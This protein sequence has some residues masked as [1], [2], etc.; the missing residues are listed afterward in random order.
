MGERRG[1]A[2]ATVDGGVLIDRRSGT[3][4]SH[5]FLFRIRL[6]RSNMAVVVDA[7]LPL[8]DG[9]PDS[10]PRRLLAAAP[11]VSIELESM[12]PLGEETVPF[13]WVYG[14][15]PTAFEDAAAD[16]PAIISVERLETAADRA[17]YRVE[18]RVDSPVVDCLRRLDAKILRAHGTANRWSITAWFPEREVAGRFRECCRDQGVVVEVDS[19]HSTTAVD[20]DTPVTPAQREALVAAYERGYF[21]QPRRTDQQ[22]LANHL[23]ISASAVGGRLRR[24]C[25]NLVEATLH[26]G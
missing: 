8:T 16:D 24:G 1:G 20:S 25:A 6:V 3:P 10:T 18:W 23:G 15:D 9:A 21:E 5:E 11:G 19:V 2:R 12:V 13:V 7:T 14:D 22:D 26:P 17:L 4:P